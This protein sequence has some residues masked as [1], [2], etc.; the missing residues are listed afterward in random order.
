[1]E[2]KSRSWQRQKSVILGNLTKV[3]GAPNLLQPISLNYDYME[4]TAYTV[5]RLMNSY[6]ALVRIFSE[7]H[8]RIPD[9]TPSSI[10]DFGT[11]P[12]TAIWASKSIWP[13]EDAAAID[14]SKSMLSIASHIA[15]AVFK[16]KTF[17]VKRHLTPTN[18]TFPLVVSAFTLSEIS[19]EAFRSQII[20][21]LWKSC[22]DTL[23]LVDRGTPLGF[24]TILKARNQIL[25]KSK[26][27]GSD[28]Y[29]VSPVFIYFSDVVFS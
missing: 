29:I 18:Q 5:G 3:N 28:C 14:I 19:S 16:M 6:S 25:T 20:D 9:F 24:E 4:S 7:M 17:E 22:S 27:T 11:G 12:G 10:L 26:E 23:V 8:K 15:S 21:A 13:I 1:M 2:V